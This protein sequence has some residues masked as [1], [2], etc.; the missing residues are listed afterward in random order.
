MGLLERHAQQGL[1]KNDN[2]YSTWLLLGGGS[3]RII[4]LSGNLLNNV[5]SFHTG[6]RYLL[7]A[8]SI[9]TTGWPVP[10]RLLMN[11]FLKGPNRVHTWICQTESV[12]GVWACRDAEKRFSETIMG[13][14]TIFCSIL[15]TALD[16]CLGV[17]MYMGESWFFKLF[18]Q[19]LRTS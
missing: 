4:L 9:K 11:I 16:P 17:C 14:W 5:A 6:E 13:K 15:W 8:G 1:I 3:V 12:T 7:L 19:S 10:R 2:R 18:A